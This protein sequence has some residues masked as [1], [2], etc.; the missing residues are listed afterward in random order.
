MYFA[1]IIGVILMFLSIIFWKRGNDNEP[2]LSS[3]IDA[4]IG[5]FSGFTF[6]SFSILIFII[7]FLILVI[8]GLYMMGIVTI[9]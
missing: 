6:R 9:S 4:F 3:V 2:L 5:I 8:T 1:L 7:G